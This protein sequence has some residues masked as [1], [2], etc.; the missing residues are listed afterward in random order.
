VD[1]RSFSSG[2]VVHTYHAGSKV[3]PGWS[4]QRLEEQLREARG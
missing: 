1:S 4:D 2:V 3:E